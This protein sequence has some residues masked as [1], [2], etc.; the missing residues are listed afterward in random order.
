MAAD[1]SLGPPQIIV[2]RRDSVLGA[3]EWSPDG[4]RIAYSG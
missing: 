1:P 3:F 2:P 4:R